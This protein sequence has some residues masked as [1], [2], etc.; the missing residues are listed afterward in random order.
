MI[1]TASRNYYKAVLRIA[2]TISAGAVSSVNE[3]L[4]ALLEG[5]LLYPLFNILPVF[6]QIGGKFK[7]TELILLSQDGRRCAWMMAFRDSEIC[8]YVRHYEIILICCNTFIF[9][10]RESN[11]FLDRSARNLFAHAC[12]LLAAESSLNHPMLSDLSQE[13]HLA[14]SCP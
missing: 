8:T 7:C 13:V 3:I 9:S 5:Y 1:R 10:Y 11:L 4:M 6:I 2:V 14:F 12:P